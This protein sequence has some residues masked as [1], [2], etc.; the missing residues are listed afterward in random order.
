MFASRREQHVVSELLKR[1]TTNP[2]RIVGCVV[3]SVHLRMDCRSCGVSVWALGVRVLSAPDVVGVRLSLLPGDIP[4]EA[5]AAATA[6]SSSNN[7]TATASPSAISSPPAA[8]V[9]CTNAGLHAGSTNGSTISS[10]KCE[11]AAEGH[12][13]AVRATTVPIPSLRSTNAPTT[14]TMTIVDGFLCVN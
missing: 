5:A 8:L 13:A 12:R 6:G 10:F 3:I 11:N 1:L 9:L 14:T 4:V 2:G 7:T